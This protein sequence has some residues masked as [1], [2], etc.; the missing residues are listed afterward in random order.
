MQPQV[1]QLLESLYKRH[2]RH[3]LISIGE[4]L[5]GIKLPPRPVYRNIVK[6]ALKVKTFLNEDLERSYS[7]AGQRFNV[8]R[9]RISQ[10]MKIIDNVPED[11][12]IKLAESDD[13]NM[14]KRFSGKVL[15]RIARLEQKERKAFIKQLT[16][17]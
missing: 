8:S 13:Q 15:Y 2:G 11:F 12:I 9:A 16:S 7:S 3:T 14:L 1:I 4:K 5:P 17:P 6:E 10:L